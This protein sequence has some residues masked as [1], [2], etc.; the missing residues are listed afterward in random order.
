M[1]IVSWLVIG[2]VLGSIARMAMPGPAAGGMPVAILIGIIG[3]LIGGIVGT[4]VVE[5]GTE[6]F[7]IPAL[8]AA[9]GAMY[10]LFAYRC[11]ALR[12]ENRIGRLC[13]PVD[14]CNQKCVI[15]SN[16]ND[17]QDVT[18]PSSSPTKLPS[19]TVPLSIGK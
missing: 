12:F 6:P 7:Y 5:N 11:F 15:Q 10:P 9:A 17:T 16:S 18:I 8:T 4:T 19:T 14:D 1:L 3:A 2:L 13:Q